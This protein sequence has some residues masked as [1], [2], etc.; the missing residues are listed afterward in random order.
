MTPR[1]LA[2]SAGR[3]SFIGGS[4]ARIIMGDDK[5]AL[6]RLWKEKRGEVEPKDLS[7]DLLVQLGALTE[8]LNQHWYEKNV[9]HS[10]GMQSRTQ[11]VRFPGLRRRTPW[12][13]P[14]SSMNSTPADLIAPTIR[15]AVSPRPPR[16]PSKASRRLMVGIDTSAAFAKS[17]CDQSS[18]ARAALTWR[19]DTFSID[20]LSILVDTFSIEFLTNQT[21]VESQ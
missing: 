6:L 21:W 11:R 17:S 13:P 12:P 9:G 4:D 2:D 14:F 19:I 15:S 10:V 7:G 16:G 8:H 3:R 1:M 20:F 5:A 18:S